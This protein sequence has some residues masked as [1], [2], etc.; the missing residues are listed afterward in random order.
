MDEELAFQLHEREA[1]R[2]LRQPS[3]K[4]RRRSKKLRSLLHHLKPTRVRAHL[5]LVWGSSK[6]GVVQLPGCAGRLAGPG[7]YACMHRYSPC[8]LAARLGAAPCITRHVEKQTTTCQTASCWLRASSGAHG[9]VKTYESS[10][11]GLCRHVTGSQAG[12]VDHAAAHSASSLPG[13]S[14]C[15]LPLCCAGD[16]QG[17]PAVSPHRHL[18]E[19]GQEQ[20]TAAP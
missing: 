20:A 4:A 3:S 5:H 14:A 10:S 18:C 9:T 6:S 13:M 11:C 19:R 8:A 17:E 15:M 12:C 2:L 1:S 7:R 16:S